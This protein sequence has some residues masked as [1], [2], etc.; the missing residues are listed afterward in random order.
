MPTDP[1]DRSAVEETK[2]ASRHLRAELLA[3]LA[4]EDD[5]FT[6]DGAAVLKFHGIYQQDDRDVRRERKLKRLGLA[7]RCKILSKIHGEALVPVQ[8]LELD[9]LADQIADATLRTTTR[10]DIQYHYVHKADLRPL[11]RAVNEAHLTTYGACGDV[12][13]N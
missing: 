1:A 4:G 8:Y 2:E 9:R 13:R 7:Y 3:E 12:V 10:Q 6:G 5:E 11:V